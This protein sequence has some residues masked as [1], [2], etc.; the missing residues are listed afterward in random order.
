MKTDT[1]K[2]YECPV[3]YYTGTPEKEKADNGIMGP[4]HG[5]WVIGYYCPDCGVKFKHTNR[6]KEVTRY[7]PIE[8]N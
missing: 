5:S 3:C 4:G 8:R 7:K 6:W 2:E 1:P